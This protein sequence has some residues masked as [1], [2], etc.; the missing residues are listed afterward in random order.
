MLSQYFD[1]AQEVKS[2][3]VEILEDELKRRAELGYYVPEDVNLNL[4]LE[5]RYGGTVDRLNGSLVVNINILKE[6]TDDPEIFPKYQPQLAQI[7]GWISN[8]RNLV[9]PGKDSIIDNSLVELLVNPD[10]F[11]DI[12]LEVLTPD[13]KEYYEKVIPTLKQDAPTIMAYVQGMMDDTLQRPFDYFRGTIRH[14]LEHTDPQFVALQDELN[15]KLLEISDDA[16]K[17][18]NGSR[19]LSSEQVRRKAEDF[20]S[21]AAVLKPAEEVRAFFCQYFN[22]K[23]TEETISQKRQAVEYEVAGKYLLGDFKKLILDVTSRQIYI[24][25]A[26]DGLILDNKTV[27][28]V[29]EVFYSGTGMP[30]ERQINKANIDY[31]VA[32]RMFGML[33]FWENKFREGMINALDNWENFYLDKIAK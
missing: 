31:N 30:V 11:D 16:Q 26:N 13:R 19:H 21:K 33:G 32:N 7:D 24:E 6:V 9:A 28:Y 25:L 8:V 20:L 22:P 3:L 12:D 29:G 23:D 15:E 17:Y 27:N 10:G 4:I 18:Q 2:R 1:Q 5:S 14:E